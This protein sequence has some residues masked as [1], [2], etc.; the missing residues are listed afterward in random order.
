MTKLMKRTLCPYV[1]GHDNAVCAY[2]FEVDFDGFLDDMGALYD[3][4]I[5]GK[6]P[7]MTIETSKTRTTLSMNTG[8]GHQSNNSP[9]HDYGDSS[10]F[11]QDLVHVNVT[12]SAAPDTTAPSQSPSP[13]GGI[14]GATSPGTAY[15][16]VR[17]Y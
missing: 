8:L 6:V 2:D 5:G 17:G 12:H 16:P 1:Y 7:L 14:P 9:K 10:W 3:S 13:T 4:V 11:S 15:D